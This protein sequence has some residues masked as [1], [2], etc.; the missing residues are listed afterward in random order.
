MKKKERDSMANFEE[1]WNQLDLSQL[2]DR[3]SKK[4]VAMMLPE[5]VKMLREYSEEIK[6][7]PRPDLN[8]FDYEAIQDQIVLA[9]KRN[10]EIKIKRWKEGEFIYNR[11]T[12]QWIDLR[13]RTIELED[14]FRSFELYID[15]IV[16]VSLL[17]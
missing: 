3:G 15:E 11:G 10:V 14:P 4:W 16:D 7:E 17:E 1:D 9:M 2:Q 5:H 13:K 12:I 6:K 8:E